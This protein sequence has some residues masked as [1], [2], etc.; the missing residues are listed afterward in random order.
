MYPSVKTIQTK[1]SLDEENAKRIRGL[2]DKTISPE[3][4]E[5]VQ[6]WLRQCWNRPSDTE[7]IM[8]AINDAL[9]THGVEAI[10]GEWIDHYHQNIQ[11]TYCNTGDSYAPTVLYCNK[12]RKFLITSWANYY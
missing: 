8:C 10:Q 2:M 4:S 11:A 9:G 6:A 12:Q 1:L 5:A 7:L 3:T